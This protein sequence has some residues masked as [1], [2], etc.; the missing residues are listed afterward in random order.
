M[1]KKSM[2]IVSRYQGYNEERRL[3]GFSKGRSRII[4]IK[5]LRSTMLKIL[6]RLVRKLDGIVTLELTSQSVAR[7]KAI[8]SRVLPYSRS[9][10]TL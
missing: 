4:R 2:G 9:Q 1:L 8:K 6:R 10:D 7:V 5:G 3:E